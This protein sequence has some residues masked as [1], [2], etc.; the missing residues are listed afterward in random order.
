MKATQVLPESYVLERRLDD[1]RYKQITW[2][3]ILFG[4][5][6]FLLSFALFNNLAGVLRPEY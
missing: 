4:L 2:V 6:F 5:L 1:T 3:V